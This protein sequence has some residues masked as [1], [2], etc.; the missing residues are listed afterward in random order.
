MTLKSS[1]SDDLVMCALFSALFIISAFIKIPLGTV[2]ITLQTLFVMLSGII[3]RRK[4]VISIC[5]YIALGLLG[6]PVFSGGGGIGYILHP[7]FGYILGFVL[8]SFVLGNICE[9]N[10]QNSFVSYFLPTLLALIIIYLCGTFYFCLITKF[11]TKEQIDFFNILFFGVLVFLP[12]DLA[13]C[14][15]SSLIAKR[16]TRLKH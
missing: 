5:I 9:K 4:S 12:K 3:L 15:I 2:P 1:K 13:F 16:I 14:I 11:Y 8:A 6:L 10:A 7:T